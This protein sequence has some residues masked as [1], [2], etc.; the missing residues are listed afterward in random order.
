MTAFQNFCAARP[1]ERRHDRDFQQQQQ[2]SLERPEGSVRTVTRNSDT[3]TCH[4]RA[5]DGRMSGAEGWARAA[6][7]RRRIMLVRRTRLRG[8][9]SDWAPSA[10][11]FSKNRNP[12]LFQRS[13]SILLFPPA[14]LPN[15][16]RYHSV[17]Q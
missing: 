17:A 4:G 13:Q 7:S 15:R 6:A 16:Q 5:T 11:G 2:L 9:L 14:R 8:P 1:T 12:N 3:V 10:H